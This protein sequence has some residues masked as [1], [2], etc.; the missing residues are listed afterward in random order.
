MPATGLNLIRAIKRNDSLLDIDNCPGVPAQMGKA[1]YGD[2]QDDDDETII[3]A[4][5]DCLTRIRSLID[6]SGGNTE[7]AVWHLDI[8]GNTHHFVVVPWHK[9]SQELVYTVF[10]AYENK[11]TLKK[12]INGTTPAPGRG[13][14]G[15]KDSWTSKQLRTM[16]NK[17]INIA[18][19]W[20]EYFG[21]VGAGNV[22]SIRCYKYTNISLSD[23]INNVNEYNGQ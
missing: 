17:L 18:N 12:Y 21:A 5:R 6:F 11:Y 23:A 20:E 10:M 2:W 19:L 7:T 14:K 15:Y 3:E 16:L 22:E 1:F 4:G 9:P 13:V 8:I